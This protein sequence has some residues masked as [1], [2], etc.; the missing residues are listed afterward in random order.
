MRKIVCALAALACAGAGAAQTPAFDPREW[1][2]DQAGAP[3]QM[4]TLGSF[5]LSQ[6][7]V[8]VN[9]AMMGALLD[10]LAA[11]KPD[12]ITVEQVSGEQCEH[13]KRYVA[14]YPD[15]YG[16]WCRAPDVAQKA[17]GMDTPAALAEIQKTLAAWPAQ[18]TPAQR[19]RLAALFMAAGD[20][21]SAGVQWRRLPTEERRVGDGV[22]EDTITFLERKGA[23]PDE[24]YDV[25][26][27]LAVRLGLERVYQV[28]DHTSDGAFAD[29]GAGY[30]PAVEAAWKVAPSKAVAEAQAMEAA[31]KT[32]ADVLEVYRF[33]N[34]PETQRRNIKADMGANLAYQTP[35]LYGRHYVS[36]WQL[37]NLRMVSNIVAV[38]TLHPGARVLN[39]VGATHKAYYDAYLN[40]IHDV[41]LVDAEEVLK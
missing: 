13:M 5:H 38:A 17:V 36:G 30:G 40:M 10:K 37:R 20:W 4:L 29:E 31:M 34:R 21:P 22:G 18:P 11:Y 28:D 16:T 39:I 7:P 9:E 33:L 32:P 26:V 19:R 12:I 41:K 6:A 8:A 24:T 25:A 35:E 23:K 14:I 3:T 27:A 1:K 2:G 15:S